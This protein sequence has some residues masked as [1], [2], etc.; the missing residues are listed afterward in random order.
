ML[1]DAKNREMIHYKTE[2]LI[3][4]NAVDSVESF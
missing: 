3:E 2:N 1:R 4:Q